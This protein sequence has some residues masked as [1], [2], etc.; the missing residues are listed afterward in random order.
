MCIYFALF[1]VI[2]TLCH[3][4]IGHTLPRLRDVLTLYTSM[5]HGVTVKDLCCRYNPHGLK[6]DEK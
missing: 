3:C 4:T 5:T 6:I 2:F 1:P